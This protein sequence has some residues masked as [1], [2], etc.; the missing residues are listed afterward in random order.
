[1]LW[2]R[3]LGFGFRAH[4]QGSVFGASGGMGILGLYGIMEQKTET[5]IVYRGF[6]RR[7]CMV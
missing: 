6:I 7:H 5:I 3:G 1:M 2:A 4:G